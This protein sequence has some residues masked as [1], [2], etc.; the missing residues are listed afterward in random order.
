MI[1]TSNVLFESSLAS[2]SPVT[3]SPNPFLHFISQWQPPVLRGSDVCGG[4]DRDVCGEK[5]SKV[6]TVARQQHVANVKE[7]LP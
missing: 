1:D 5:F 6:L 4:L 3:K 7:R 2:H